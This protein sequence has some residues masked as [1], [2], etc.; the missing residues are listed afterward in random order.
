MMEEIRIVEWTSEFQDGS[1]EVTYELQAQDPEKPR[2]WQPLG[3]SGTLADARKALLFHMTNAACY[4][5]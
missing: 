2:N 1:R 5:S 3:L 4:P